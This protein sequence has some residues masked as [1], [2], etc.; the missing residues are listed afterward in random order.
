MV[1]K[2]KSIWYENEERVCTM[3]KIQKREVL[4][5][6]WKGYGSLFYHAM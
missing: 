4:G 5:V 3:N 6:P 1:K 2:N